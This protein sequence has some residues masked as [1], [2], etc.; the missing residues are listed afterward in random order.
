MSNSRPQQRPC[1]TSVVPR[2][3]K[4]TLDFCQRPPSVPGTLRSAV[5][6]AV[7]CQK[8]AVKLCN[9]KTCLRQ[10]EGLDSHRCRVEC[11]ATPTHNCHQVH[12]LLV[13]AGLDFCFGFGVAKGDPYRYYCIS[14]SATKQSKYAHH[15]LL[16]FDKVKGPRAAKADFWCNLVLPR[17]GRLGNCQTPKMAMILT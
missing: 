8:E 11:P 6:C 17:V 5:Y 13:L 15:S 7:A 10:P 14:N 16:P 12:V 9:S 4:R 3:G 1:P 2:T